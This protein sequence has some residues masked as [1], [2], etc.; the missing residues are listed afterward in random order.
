MPSAHP[1]VSGAEDSLKNPSV[2]WSLLSSDWS[3]FQLAVLLS[4]DFASKKALLS[5]I[6]QANRFYHQRNLSAMQQ[7]ISQMVEEM[8]IRLLPIKIKEKASDLVSL[9]RE[10]GRGS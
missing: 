10:M 9:L 4:Q 1:S 3:E 6:E 7:T 8:R 5:S 2:S